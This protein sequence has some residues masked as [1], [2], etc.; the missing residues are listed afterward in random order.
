MT[1]TVTCVEYVDVI[2][3]ARVVTSTNHHQLGA[4][5]RATTHRNARRKC[6]GPPHTQKSKERNASRSKTHV[7]RDEEEVEEVVPSVAVCRERAA[8]DVPAT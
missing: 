4:H 8:G 5:C 2:V 7:G 3:H 1:S 6:Q